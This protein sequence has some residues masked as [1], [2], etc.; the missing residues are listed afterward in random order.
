MPCY[1]STNL[2]GGVTTTGRTSYKTEADCLQACRE[3]A[4]CEGTTCTVKPQC[5]CQ[6]TGKTFKGVGTVCSP[7]PCGCCGNGESI[8]GKTATIYLSTD[9]IPTARWCPK[10]DAFGSTFLMCPDRVQYGGCWAVRP[11]LTPT[12][13]EWVDTAKTGITAAY[14]STAPASNCNAGLEGVCP[15]LG[16]KSASVG[17]TGPPCKIY[18]VVD[19]PSLIGASDNYRGVYA[20][21]PYWAWDYDAQTTRYKTVYYVFQYIDGTGI[22]TVTQSVNSTPVPPTYPS[23]SGANWFLFKT[24]TV[25]MSLTL[26]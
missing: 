23:G 4:C 11:C 7:N 13:G 21:D 25:T 16:L 8:A 18:A 15:G 10:P 6:G 17:L 20:V 22:T 9:Q 14:S 1:Q 19:C 5:Q 2:P 3:G 24:T 26:V 12:V